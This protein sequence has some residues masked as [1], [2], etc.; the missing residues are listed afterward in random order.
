MQAREAKKLSTFLCVSRKKYR[1][2]SEIKVWCV[3]SSKIYYNGPQMLRRFIHQCSAHIKSPS[4]IQMNLRRGPFRAWHVR[5]ISLSTIPG[6][7]LDK[8][9]RYGSLACSLSFLV[10]H[11]KTWSCNGAR[12]ILERKISWSERCKESSR[13]QPEHFI[14]TINFFFCCVLQFFHFI[15]RS[16]ELDLLLSVKFL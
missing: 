10:L 1:R 4:E 3:N 12:C 15:S 6:L 2:R 8:S 16:R 5:L 13:V 14:L 7:R 11:F 9:L